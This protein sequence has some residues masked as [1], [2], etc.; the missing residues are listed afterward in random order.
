MRHYQ[1]STYPLEAPVSMRLA[2]VADLHNQQGVAAAEA[3]RSLSPD[4]VLIVGELFETPP[5]RNYFRYDEAVAF[6]RALS[7]IPMFYSRG[8]HDF[9]LPAEMKEV[10]EACGVVCLFDSYT[11][12][13]G[14]WI[15]GL[16]SA[17]F[18]KGKVPNLDFLNMFASLDGYKLILSHHPEYF[19]HI[20][21]LPI[22]LTVSGHAHGGQWRLFG[23]GIYSPGQGLFPKY[24]SGLYHGARLLVSRG[25]KVYT[26]PVPRLWNPPEILLLSLSSET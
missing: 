8:N 18:E 24:T 12:F 19:R 5:R 22:H 4:A 13:R 26:P 1:I 9:Q 23:Q 16:T 21:P 20:Q 11:S 25:M 15:G 6:L 7:G 2:V 17:Q 10:M 14:I 3:V